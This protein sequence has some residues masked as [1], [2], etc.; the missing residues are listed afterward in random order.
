MQ[1]CVG[2]GCLHVCGW[3]CVGGCVMC[4]WMCDVWVDV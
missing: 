4:G 3:M 1:R 2:E